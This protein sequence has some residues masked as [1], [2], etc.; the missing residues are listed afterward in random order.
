MYC[1]SLSLNKEVGELEIVGVG[2]GGFATRGAHVPRC[3][4]SAFQNGIAPSG[5]ASSTEISPPPPIQLQASGASNV[6]TDEVGVSANAY[7]V[8][9]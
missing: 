9:N 8:P 5:G 2:N 3:S 1:I 7:W 4:T 6:A